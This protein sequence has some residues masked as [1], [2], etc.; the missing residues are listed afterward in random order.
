MRHR[1]VAGEVRPQAPR[2]FL[3]TMRWKCD[4]MDRGVNSI[5][6]S[7]AGFGGSGRCAVP[8]WAAQACLRCSGN[9]TKTRRRLRPGAEAIPSIGHGCLINGHCLADSS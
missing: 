6:V 9:G 2:M 5:E 8:T 3:F 1:P 4:D 7:Q